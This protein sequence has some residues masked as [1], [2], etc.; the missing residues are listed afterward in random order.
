MARIGPPFT[1]CNARQ[2]RSG[3]RDYW[4]FRHPKVGNVRLPGHPGCRE[5]MDKYKALVVRAGE[6][7][8]IRWGMVRRGLAADAQAAM[9]HVYFIGIEPE[10]P[11]K[12]GHTT[13]IDIRLAKL[14]HASPY[15]LT[16]LA[17]APGGSVAETALHRTF[18]SNR[19][20]GEWFERTPEL[21]SLIADIRSGA[22]SL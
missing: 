12:I 5:F 11:I 2:L 8:N 16:V 21:L 1:Y 4:Y 19:I 10:G 15:L 6:A 14:Q 9:S 7:R 17:V 20:R 22:F 3:P 18:A 13:D